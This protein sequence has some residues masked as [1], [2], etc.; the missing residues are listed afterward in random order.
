MKSQDYILCLVCAKWNYN[1]QSK[2]V[3]ESKLEKK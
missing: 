3:S 2:K 1:I